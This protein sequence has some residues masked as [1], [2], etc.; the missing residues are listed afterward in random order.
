MKYNNE[1]D[2][3]GGARRDVEQGNSIFGALRNHVVLRHRVKRLQVH[4][5]LISLVDAG[6][7]KQHMD[8]HINVST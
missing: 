6:K 5:H 3:S 2:R 4:Q 8:F 1:A 7:D